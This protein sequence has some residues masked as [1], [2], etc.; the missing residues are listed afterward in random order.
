[1][2]PPHAYMHVTIPY[3]LQGHHS[4]RSFSSSSGILHDEVLSTL[5]ASEIVQVLLLV[6]T[7]CTPYLAMLPKFITIILFTLSIFTV[8]TISGAQATAPST[9]P[10]TLLES[11]TPIFVPI[12]D[13]GR[14]FFPLTIR[15]FETA[16]TVRYV[17]IYNLVRYDV[18]AVCNPPALSFF[19]IRDELPFKDFC[20]P[21][22]VA[23]AKAFGLHAILAQE[24]PTEAGFL[25]AYL[26]SLGLSPDSDAP[27]NSP[28]AFARHIA[29]RAN[30]YL[31]KDGWN[32]L[33]DATR[34][35]FR[36]PYS[37][38]S[39]YKPKNLADKPLSKIPFPLR[40][41]PLN[42]ATSPGDFVSQVHV[43][44]H[45]AIV[46]PLALSSADLA[47][48]R[49]PSPY[50]HPSRRKNVSKIDARR[51]EKLIRAYFVRS[52]RQ[53]SQERFFS[54]FW[55]NKLLS[56]SSFLPFYSAAF[57]WSEWDL[58]VLSM[59]ETVAQHDALIV[60]W[61]EKRRHDLVRPLT[62]IRKLWK[63]RMVKAFVPGVGVKTI[64][65]EE[66]ETTIQTQPH[67]EFPSATA[68]LCSS[69]FDNVQTAVNRRLGFNV[70]LPTYSIPVSEGLFRGLFE[71]EEYFTAKINNLKEAL[72]SC[73]TSRLWAGVHFEPSV[74]EGVRLGKGIG[75]K[76]QDQI[77][78]LASGKV[79]NSCSWCL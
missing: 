63:G 8:A 58:I 73:A 6:C 37:D 48:R 52:E 23:K 47:A 28:L 10:P 51:L 32:S 7:P 2:Y 55:D 13:A 49:A 19:G 9:G 65:A 29:T 56:V 77:L 38:T 59:A 30:S 46:R 31:S 34:T 54:R 36:Q 14:A 18:L 61:K 74:K 75:A 71:V 35:D 1:M 33:G 24:F 20:R 41:Q 16:L 42:Q 17:H 50:A 12:N 5:R 76:A 22:P 45:L 57:G 64:R 11:L 68:M 70:T 4:W 25:A 21:L 62:I 43:V 67:S 66:Y 27:P 3:T 44:P 26:T 79:P 53:T 40:W 72:D 39:G 15:A 60:S 69:T 78:S